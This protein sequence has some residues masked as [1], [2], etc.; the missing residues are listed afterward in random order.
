[1]QLHEVWSLQSGSFNDTCSLL[2]LMPQSLLICRPFNT[3]RARFAGSTS[4]WGTFLGCTKVTT[5]IDGQPTGPLIRPAV[6]PL[7]LMGQG[8]VRLT[9]HDTVPFDTTGYGPINGYH[10][11]EPLVTISSG[12]I[13]E[14]PLV[15]THFFFLQLFLIE[16]VP[17]YELINHRMLLTRVIANICTDVWCI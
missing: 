4:P 10:L 7:F 6:K 8:G 5:V 12:T 9:S 16:M 14:L 15:W 2:F 17:K 3:W 11:Q 13:L 1:M